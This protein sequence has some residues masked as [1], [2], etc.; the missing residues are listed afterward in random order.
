MMYNAYG[1]QVT[2]PAN[3]YRH[4]AYVYPTT[5]YSTAMEISL[6]LQVVAGGWSSFFLA[7]SSNGTGTSSVNAAMFKLESAQQAQFGYDSVSGMSWGRWQG[8]WVTLNPTLGTVTTA[9]TGNLHW[10]ASPMQTQAITLPKTGTFT[11]TY[12]GGTTPTD[13]NGTLGALVG[14][15]AFSADW[16]AQT[17]SLTGLSV[18]MPASSGPIGTFGA[19]QMNA[20]ASGVPILPGAN[21]KTT[22]TVTCNP[23]CPGATG[24]IGGQFAGKGGLG[25][26]IGYGLQSGSQVINGVSAFRR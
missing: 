15:P 4:V 7:P 19:V 23:S 1:T 18:S 5:S 13:N 10:F 12:A 24:V 3:G 16:S 22:P 2:I 20:S 9:T 25:V 11:Y 8:S 26:G 6:D 21:F 17:V 14:T